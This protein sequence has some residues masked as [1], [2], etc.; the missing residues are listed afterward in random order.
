[1]KGSETMQ[2]L[3]GA[4]VKKIQSYIFESSRLR[5][6]AGGSEL[7]E[8]ICTDLFRENFMK[9][10]SVE[11]IIQAAGN[12]RAV[13]SDRETA[14]QIMLNFPKMVSEAAPGVQLVQAIV[15]LKHDQ[16]TAADSQE[17]EKLLKKQVPFQSPYKD[18]SVTRKAPRSGKPVYMEKDGEVYD[19]SAWKK[20]QA[21]ENHWRNLERKFNVD[22]P[23]QCDT[24]KLAG[25]DHFVAVI[26][27]DGNSLGKTLMN[28]QNS[29]DYGKQWREFS[30]QLDSATT[31]AAKR[32]Y[33]EIFSNAG[34]KFRAIILGGDD[35][36]V[37]CAAEYAIDFTGKYLEYFKEECAA[38]PVL[39]P[40]TACAGIAFIKA[41][42]PFYYGAELAEMLCAAAKKA[43]KSC[44]E[45][46]VPSS[47]MFAR[48][49]GSFVDESFPAFTERNLKI[50]TDQGKEIS[51]VFGPYK[52][53]ADEPGGEKLPWIEDL[54]NG[55]RCFSAADE[56]QNAKKQ[57]RA[58]LH[59]AVRKMLTELHVSYHSA[60]MLAARAEDIAGERDAENLN[61][62]KNCL[63][64][65]SG[66]KNDAS[67]FELL[68]GN[69]KSPIMDLL[70]AYQFLNNEKGGK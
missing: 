31:C 36:T 14:A 45:D 20:I 58:A 10:G 63:A 35:L 56:S 37:V 3:Y 21:V 6:I 1:M 64:A 9:D 59:S 33:D 34:N 8:Y 52:T 69:G 12:I 13:V 18:W 65:L 53:S 28:L 62:L 41:G 43:A 27:A 44:S 23:F 4:S 29:P 38:R 68:C 42:Y 11:P 16:L 48:E 47:F 51:L 39:G 50:R 22:Q 61:T 19:I 66:C 26:H 46:P 30:Q 67:L 54:L 70:T 2:F 24:E 25:K 40:L 15:E 17:L 57:P 32:S 49:L 55:A 7:V 60:E 5:E